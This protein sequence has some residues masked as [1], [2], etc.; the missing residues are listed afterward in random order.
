MVIVLSYGCMLTPV[1]S[2]TG[3]SDPKN[4]RDEEYRFSILFI[5]H[6]VFISHVPGSVLKAGDTVINN[7]EIFHV[8]ME[9]IAQ[10]ERSKPLWYQ[11]CDGFLKCLLVKPG[12][13]RPR[14]L[15]LG[16]TS[17]SFLPHCGEG[18]GT[19]LQYFCLEN[20]MDG[21][22]WWAAARGAL[23]VR[24]DWATSLSHIGEG[25][26]NPLQ[27]SCLENPRDGKASWAAVYGVA[28][29][30]H[31]WSNSAAAVDSLLVPKCHLA[32]PILSVAQGFHSQQSW[33]SFK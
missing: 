14:T 13:P 25:N 5:V 27:C 18:N 6:P 22:A 33:D 4:Y 8:V 1:I 11:T 12:L 17:C 9:F 7:S 15:L 21:G 19:P 24:H 31:D 2:A 29:V 32:S 20:P 26:G 16:K 28:R 23:W 10:Q 3:W 30:E